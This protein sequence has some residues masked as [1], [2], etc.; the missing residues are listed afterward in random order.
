MRKNSQSKQVTV[1]NAT[2]LSIQKAWCDLK[3]TRS[4][5]KYLNVL[6]GHPLSTYSEVPNNSFE[7]IIN[8]RVFGTAKQ[9]LMDRRLFGGL[10]M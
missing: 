2:A 9:L 10:I 7:T 4:V 8:I 1:Q 3:L 5:Y 6:G